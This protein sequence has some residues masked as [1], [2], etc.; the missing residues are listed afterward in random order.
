MSSILTTS[1]VSREN[2]HPQKTIP[3]STNLLRT[4]TSG[5]Y[6]RGC[7]S[8]A[9][10]TFGVRSVTR[11]VK[12]VKA[13]GEQVARVEFYADKVVVIT[14]AGSGLEPGGTPETETG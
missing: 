3:N 2:Y 14:M 9:P 8:Q 4:L 11:A 13:A 5:D 12:A 10:S 1:I 7:M 6:A